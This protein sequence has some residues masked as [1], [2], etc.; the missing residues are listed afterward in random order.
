[1]GLRSPLLWMV[2]RFNVSNLA[3]ILILTLL[4]SLLPQTTAFSM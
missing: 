4:F 1:L 3:H 2:E